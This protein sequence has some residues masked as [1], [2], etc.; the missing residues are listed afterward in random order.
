[1]GSGAGSGSAIYGG[2]CGHPLVTLMY[3][4]FGRTF[5][6]LGRSGDLLRR[7]LPKLE[8]WAC[9]SAARQV[10]MPG[11]FVVT[12]RDTGHCRLWLLV[13]LWLAQAIL[14]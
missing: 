2:D 12:G 9:P 10:L 6:F 4:W 14:T 1:M 7:A 3:R 8:G 5:R 13:V 11:V